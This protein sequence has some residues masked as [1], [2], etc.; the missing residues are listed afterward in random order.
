MVSHGGNIFAVAEAAQVDFRQ[1]LDFSASINPLGMSPAVKEAIL[2]AMERVAHYPERTGRRVR[3]AL[4]SHWGV[5]PERIRVGHGA[6]ELLFAWC[7]E[8]GNGTIAAPAFGEFHAAWPEARLC[9]LGD[10][11]SWPAEGAVVLTRPANPTG[12][13]VSCELVREYARGR[14]GA[15]L[16]DESF[17]D[18]CEAESLMGEARGNLFVLRSLTKF[19]ALPGLRIGALVGDVGEMVTIPWPVN[20]L[21]E[22][23]AVAAVG[24]V[25]W[26]RRTREFVK[27]EAGWLA[28]ELS[29]L[30]GVKVW[31]PTA[32]YVFVETARGSEWAAFAGERRVLLRDCGGWPG[33][34]AQGVRVAVRRRWENEVL[35]RLSKEFLCG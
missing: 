22:A 1:V 21:A 15:V 31:A 35:V 6:T 33:W 20:A 28:G 2:V 7:R 10:R 19:W 26:A 30:P 32:N 4:A 16:V 3:E 9:R 13:L 8:Q 5:A 25:E 24:D 34:P 11:G 17:L 18:F 12:E 14:R 27:A 23:A 29:G